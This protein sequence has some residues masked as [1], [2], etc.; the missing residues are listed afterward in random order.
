M[1]RKFL[2]GVGLL[3][4]AATSAVLA[5]PPLAEKVSPEPCDKPLVLFGR[6]RLALRADLDAYFEENLTG[7]NP[8]FKAVDLNSTDWNF[9]TVPVQKAGVVSGTIIVGEDWTMFGPIHG[10][11]FEF[12]VVRDCAGGPWRVVLFEKQRASQ[13]ADLAGQG[14]PAAP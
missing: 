11:T 7:A 6:D 5:G 9:D 14:V 1:R 8:V 13:V 2:A 10:S 3:A 4:V 12:K